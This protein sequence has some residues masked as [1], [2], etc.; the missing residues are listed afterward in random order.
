MVILSNF[1]KPPENEEGFYNVTTCL[2]IYDPSRWHDIDL[3]HFLQ[4]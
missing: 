2:L 4:P 1:V 3:G